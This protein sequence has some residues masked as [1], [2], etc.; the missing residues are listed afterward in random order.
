V[1][2]TRGC[3]GAHRIRSSRNRVADAVAGGCA[4]GGDA[5]GL[6]KI[7]QAAVVQLCMCVHVRGMARARGL[8]AASKATQGECLCRSWG[9]GG[10]HAHPSIT[11]GT[12]GDSVAASTVERRKSSCSNKGGSQARLSIHAFNCGSLHSP[13]ESQVSRRPF[14]TADAS[15]LCQS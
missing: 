5:G 10:E 11:G 12:R 14:F 15:A 8:L 13:T 9:S 7:P 2:S 6:L 1:P 4:L 3:K